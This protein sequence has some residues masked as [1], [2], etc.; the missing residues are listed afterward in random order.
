MRKSRPG[1]RR[2][3]R[4]SS[5]F[6]DGTKARTDEVLEVLDR[7]SDQRV[8]RSLNECGT[9]DTRDP[10]NCPTIS[11]RPYPICGSRPGASP[12]CRLGSLPNLKPQW[13]QYH[14]LCK[15][16]PMRPYRRRLRARGPV[17]SSATVECFCPGRRTLRRRIDAGADATLKNAA[18][19][20]SLWQDSSVG[21]AG[22][23][24]PIRT[25]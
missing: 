13:F 25:T 12:E 4:T 20:G 6:T 21:H 11:D 2:D 5:T 10:L 19:S 17:R 7:H 16:D 8:E 1:T 3:V 24:R 23:G 14:S 9:D 18:R 15:R 22:L